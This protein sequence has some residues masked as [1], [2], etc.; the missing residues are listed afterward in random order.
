MGLSLILAIVTLVATAAS[1]AYQ[2]IQ[3]KKLRKDAAAAADA[4]K[5]FELTVEGSPDYLPIA[6]GRVLIGG[7]RTWA[8]TAS[9][10]NYVTSNATQVFTNGD[11]GYTGYGI[12]YNNWLAASSK[13]QNSYGLDPIESTVSSSPSGY[14]DKSMT[15]ERNEFLCYQQAMCVGPINRVIDMII[16]DGRYIDDP[17]L[18][19]S[20]EIAKTSTK[21]KHTAVKA[22]LRFDYHRFGG[23][24]DNIAKA[25]FGNRASALFD[26]MA[27]FTA[28]FR[29]DRDDPQFSSIPQVQTLIEGRKVRWVDDGNLST[30]LNYADDPTNYRYDNSPALCLLDYMLDNENG[31]GYDLEDIDLASF[32]AADAIC[33]QIV[34]EDVV[35]GGKIWKPTIGT[36]FGTRD[37]PLYEC[38]TIVDVKRPVRE[39]IESILSTMGDARLIWSNG[40]YSLSL[41]Y[42]TSNE[43]IDLA[44]TITDDDLVAGESV[45]LSF[46]SADSRYNFVTMRFHN[47]FENF[48]E[49]SVSWPPKFN[50]NYQ[51]GIGAKNYPVG[52]GSWDDSKVAGNLLNRYAVWNGSSGTA[53]MTW[54]INVTAST[55]GTYTIEAAGDDSYTLTVTKD[56]TTYASLSSGSYSGNT[57]QSSSINLTAPGV[58]TVTIV[59]TNSS[60]DTDD[61][62]GVGAYI[63]SGSTIL[64]ST[65]ST[66]Y[67]NFLSITESDVVYN[68]MLEEDNGVELETDVFAEGITDPYHALAKAEELCRTSR[69]ATGYKFQML[70]REYYLQPGDYIKFESE[71]LD[72]GVSPDLYLRV[73]SIKITGD[74][75]CEVE[76]TR[77]D[78]TQL[79]WNVKDDVYI[80]P[81][82]TFYDIV[83][84]PYELTYSAP[85]DSASQSSGS[86]IAAPVAYGEL[87]GYV[88]Y[89]HRAGID[90]VDDTGRPIFQEL[91]RGPSNIFTLPAI[92]SASAFFAVRAIS[93]GGKL[94]A[95]T[96]IDT[97]TATDMDHNWLRAVTITASAE[98][99]VKTSST[100]FTP[101]T[102]TLTANAFNFN[103][104]AFKWFINDTVVGTSSTLII[105][106]FTESFVNYLVQV[107][108]TGESVGLYATDS[109]KITSINTAAPG[110]DV[111]GDNV[112]GGI[113]GQGPWATYT[114]L[115][116]ATVE[117]INQFS[118]DIT[119]NTK[120][121]KEEKKRYIE[122]IN[123]LDITVP[124]EVA[125]ATAFG[126]TT[127]ATNLSNAF[128]AWKVYLA[129]E[130]YT[131]LNST[132]SINRTTFR[133]KANDFATALTAVI[134]ARDQKASEISKWSGV[135][136]DDGNRPENN[137]DI[138]LTHTSAAIVGQGSFATQSSA[139]WLTEI[140]GR[141]PA[142]E[143]IWSAINMST[144]ADVQKEFDI[145]SSG[146]DWGI[147]TGLDNSS[148]KGIYFG[149]DSG[150]DSAAFF[151]KEFIN[152]DGVSLYEV[153]FDVTIFSSTP[154][155]PALYLGVQGL[156]KAGN[157]LGGSYNYTHVV[158]STYS[159]LGGNGRY[160]YKA[161][162]QGWQNGGNYT[163]P[164]STPTNP[165]G[166]PDGSLN[167][168]GQGG[169]VKFSPMGLV[170]YPDKSGQFIIHSIRVR[171]LNGAA[172]TANEFYFGDNFLKETS[173]GVTATLSNF[174]TSVGTAAAITGQ[175]AWATYSTITPTTMSNKTQ[176]LDG[177]T[178]HLS[179]L[180]R[181]DG[182]ELTRL[183]RADNTTAVTEALV[184]TSLGTAAAISGQAATATSSDYSVITGPTKPDNYATNGPNAVL[185]PGAENGTTAPYVTHNVSGG[186][187][188]TISTSQFVSG[189]ASFALNKTSV[190]GSIAI[191]SAARPVVPGKVY[192]IRIRAKGSSSSSVG[193]YFAVYAKATQVANVTPALA[194]NTSPTSAW[195]LAVDIGAPSTWTEYLYYW[196]CP[197]GMYW[198]SINIYND[199][200]GPLSLYI[201]DIYMAEHEPDADVT[202]FVTGSKT[203]N[204]A[205]NYDGTIKAG[206][207]NYEAQF[208]SWVAGN[209]EVTTQSSWAGIL[210]QGTATFTPTVGSPNT[211]GLL[212]VTAFSSDAIIE[213]QATYN[214]KV[215][216]GALNL[217]KVTDPPPS[218]GGGGSGTTASDSTI[219]ATT[220]SSY[221][222]AQSSI[223]SVQAGTTG[224]VN[225]S[226][227]LDYSRATNGIGDAYGKWQWRVVGGSFADVT[228]EIHA[229]STSY[230]S[231]APDFENTAGSISVNMQKTGLTNGTTY[232]FQ[233]L[234]RSGGSYTVS[235]FGTSVAQGS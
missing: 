181:V 42:P 9:R 223:L 71:E 11:A 73:E 229:D 63:Y 120:F 191:A 224:V 121:T 206:Q 61:L 44:A 100:T 66:S 126:L 183:R 13:A 168:F 193:M 212:T 38:N 59:G 50:N 194:E 64:W 22:A 134:T 230:R 119:D 49:D 90:P 102:I 17:S 195:A 153:V 144:Q 23:A 211:T 69:T 32:E 215:R 29:L 72:I 48:K 78:Y 77:F 176:Y 225:L 112:A 81:Q 36:Q 221:S 20:G 35:I 232:E 198:A 177:T 25:N 118:V 97:S 151:G 180:D 213:M 178:G 123:E 31:G 132:N 115:T 89:I 103:S 45:E 68:A 172:Q 53:N 182:R 24:A 233:L 67:T 75:T 82:S 93:H 28:W 201:D 95:Y 70:I 46:P 161:Y 130:D 43:T 205:F 184:I 1:T 192:P 26:G 106:P 91:G 30:V 204:I 210:K 96:L 226:A 209:T 14:M 88:F 163:G 127:E 174:K 101:T 27:W 149:N 86:L 166:L 131:D 128:T 122:W 110:A 84:Q 85:E 169:V 65:R 173:L 117:G 57:I 74:N 94:S 218:G 60:D 111:T 196:T 16:D 160:Q 189:A 216:V 56:A 140:S 147:A 200:N 164:G 227:P 52:R 87:A 231:G 170:N 159:A 114:G 185:N 135:N 157:N 136:D 4:R 58:Y 133:T 124:E 54:L 154:T 228:T 167:G 222:G 202:S 92:N 105:S 109:I 113:V 217:L 152:Y 108:E 138:T 139:N 12:A 18:G 148:G 207:L 219:D 33:R 2:V 47:E 116:T 214:G 145:S 79:A 40:K 125:K 83:P 150:N 235:Y 199:V 146:S 156:D 80:N 55:A 19:Y 208:K 143:R 76:A 203:V 190:G 39:N 175:G 107:T 51:R 186:S 6:Y 234:L 129:S 142:E 62:K 187:T 137:A 197:A 162:L 171:R 188:F 155:L 41:Q 104:P 3:A 220:G 37:L 10:F 179:N 21:K 141:P 5:G 7:I 158:G 15:G 8:Q 165:F 99:F 34:Q 98:G